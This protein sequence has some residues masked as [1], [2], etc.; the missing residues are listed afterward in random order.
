LP[1]NWGD[2]PVYAFGALTGMKT[3]TI[4]EDI[5]RDDDRD[6]DAVEKAYAGLLYADRESRNYAKLGVGRQ[7]FTLNDG[8][9]INMVR[10]SVNAGDRGASYLGPR[11]TNEFSVLAD[12]R[13]G[14]WGFNA[15]YIDPSELDGSDTE[16]TFLGGNISYRVNDDLSFDGTLMTIP[17]SESDYKTADERTLPREGLNTAAAHLLWKNFGADGVFLEG[18]FGRQWHPD[19][20]MSAWA[21][22]GTHRLHRA[23]RPGRQACHTGMR[24][25]SGDDPDTTLRALRPAAQHRPRHLAARSSPSESSSPTRTLP[26]TACSS[27]SRQSKRSTSL[28]IIT[29]LRAPELNDVAPNRGAGNPDRQIRP[30]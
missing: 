6:F 29:F 12:G 5:F 27:T 22:Y 19:Y 17:T 9:L 20:D 16:T 4:G 28:S 25:F 18:E 15:F 11:L 2:S 30:G 8:F 7:T 26:R 13:F 23:R 10:G 24:H 3:W 1:R 14:S 21:A